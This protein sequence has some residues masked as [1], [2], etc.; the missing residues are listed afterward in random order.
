MINRIFCVG[1]V[2]VLLMAGRASAQSGASSSLTVFSG[3]RLIDGTGAVPIE[4]AT[5]VVRDGRIES[6]WIAGNRVPRSSRE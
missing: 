6:V 2:L 4:D 3:V 1:A 5:I